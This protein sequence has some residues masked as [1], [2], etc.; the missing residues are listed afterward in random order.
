M[1]HGQ[2]D[3]GSFGFPLGPILETQDMDN[4]MVRLRQGADQSWMRRLCCTDCNK[5]FTLN[6]NWNVFLDGYGNLIAS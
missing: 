5:P 3:G 1:P 6:P 2:P 4:E